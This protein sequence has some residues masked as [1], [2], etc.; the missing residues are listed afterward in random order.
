MNDKQ[1]MKQNEYLHSLRDEVKDLELNNQA[2]KK[3]VAEILIDIE[4]NKTIK[5]DQEKQILILDQN[6][7]QSVKTR[8]EYNNTLMEFL[9]V[10]RIASKFV[11]VGGNF[12]TEES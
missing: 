4:K 10:L 9:K 11:D 7:L 6:I 2:W 1:I 5:A 3:I 8:K 12:T